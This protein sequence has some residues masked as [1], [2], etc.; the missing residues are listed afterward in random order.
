MQRMH[1]LV[2]HL[3]GDMMKP[4]LHWIRRQKWQFNNHWRNGLLY[5]FF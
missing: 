1:V 3:R 2:E 4:L 5:D